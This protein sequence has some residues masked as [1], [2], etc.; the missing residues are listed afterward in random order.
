MA[1]I[2]SRPL[3]TEAFEARRRIAAHVRRTP[4]VPSA[5]LSDAAD[6]PVSL[7]LE[8][9]QVSNSFKSRG[10]FNA[11]VARLERK[12]AAGMRLVTASAGN[13]G[14]ALAAAAEAF[15]LPLVVFTPVDAPRTKLDAIRRHGAEL[16]AE[17]RDYDD[18]ERRAKAFAADT[19]AEFVSPYN[20]RDVIAGASTIA[21]EIFEDRPSTRVLIVPV[22]GGG[23]ISGL[24]TAA[25][26]ISAECQVFGVEAE[27][28]CAFQTSLRAGHLVTIVPGPTLADGLGGNPDPETVTFGIIQRS[29]DSIVT[30]SEQHLTDAI[31]GLVEREH[32]I[33]EG[34]GAAAVAAL[35]GRRLDPGQRDT[36]VLVSGANID[37]DRLAGIL[38]AP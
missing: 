26:H 1:E 18:A 33:S 7:K 3:L 36:A 35:L 32:L 5:W 19:G 4:L 27:A 12:P 17:G 20:D 16:R 9:L 31:A 8:S 22:G 34:A 21:L 24:A 29:V 6:A 10:A 37:R 30:V 14:R 38:C 13:H 23:L 28:S 15:K 25:K 11:V 2:D